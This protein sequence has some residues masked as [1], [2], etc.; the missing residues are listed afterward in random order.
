MSY[1]TQRP[2]K[3]VGTGESLAD[4]EPFYPERMASRILGMGDVLTLIEKAEQAFDQ[5]EAK[6]MEAKL[7]KAEFTFDDFLNQLQA[8]KK[9]GP[10]SQ[11]MGMLPGMSK[12]PVGDLEVDQQMPKIEA[13]I[14]SM[15]PRE[16]NDPSII[17]GSRRTRIANGSGMSV[18][19]VNALIKQFD[20]VRKLMKSMMGGKGGKMRLP[21]GMKLPPGM[22]L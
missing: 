21:A 15:T 19:D 5:T 3:F 13:M 18:R 20:Q 16:R 6:K 12:L 1:V 11:V 7:R 22:G 14:R 2:I 9:M 4:L 10:L 17:N 8:V